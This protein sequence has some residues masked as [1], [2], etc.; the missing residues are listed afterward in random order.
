MCLTPVDYLRSPNY[1]LIDLY[2][3]LDSVLARWWL[4][5]FFVCLGS[6]GGQQ[7]VPFL[8]LGSHLL[9]QCPDNR[10]VVL[11]DLNDVSYD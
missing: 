2:W 5:H 4:M 3:S 1:F 11:V 8:S 10:G 9:L 7:R 6:R